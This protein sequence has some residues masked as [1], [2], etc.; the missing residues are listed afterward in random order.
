FHIHQI[1][2]TVPKQNFTRN[3]SQTLIQPL[4]PNLFK[5]QTQKFH[6]LIPNI[7][8]H[9]IHQII[10]HPYNTLNQGRYFITSPIIKHNYQPI[11]SHIQPLPFK[12]ISQQH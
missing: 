8:P 4:P 11:H 2:L 1:A 6:I 10:Q 5:H 12:I 9:I 7:L 3:H